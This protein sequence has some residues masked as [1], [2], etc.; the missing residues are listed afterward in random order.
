MFTPGS[1]TCAYKSAS[2][3]GKWPNHDPIE[4]EGGLN[5]YSYVDN[6]PI[7]NL[8]PFGLKCKTFK[9]CWSNCMKASGADWALAALG[10]ASPAVSIPKPFGAG[11]LGSGSFTTGLSLLE[12]YTGIA[13]RQL[14]RRLNPVANVIAAGAAGYLAG[15]S[16]TCAAMCAADVNAF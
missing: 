13:A 2:G 6:N 3:L 14:G 10:V 1:R 16:G 5:L 9:D 8:D 11:A 12:H 4:E 15:L 7:N